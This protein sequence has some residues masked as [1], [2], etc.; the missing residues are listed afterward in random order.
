MKES[1]ITIKAH[2][3]EVT[4]KF[5]HEDVNIDEW[6]DAFKSCL[7]GISFTPETVNEALGDSES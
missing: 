7:I 4:V 3:L 6:I 5:D 1:S 2:G